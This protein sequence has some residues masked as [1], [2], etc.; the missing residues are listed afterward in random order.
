M[1]TL[2][3]GGAGAEGRRRGLVSL[4]HLHVNNLTIE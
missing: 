3:S 4:E 2:L 1:S